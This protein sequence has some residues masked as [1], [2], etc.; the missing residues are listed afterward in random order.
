MGKFLEL[1][2]RDK[3][4]AVGGVARRF[5]WRSSKALVNLGSADYK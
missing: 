5:T 2:H 1:L 4:P 3:R